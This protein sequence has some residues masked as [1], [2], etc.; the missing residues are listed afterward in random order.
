[1]CFRSELRLCVSIGSWDRAILQL[2]T[3][4]EVPWV[5]VRQASSRSDCRGSRSGPG[6]MPQYK[7]LARCFFKRARRGLF[8]GDRIRYGDQISEDGGNR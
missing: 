8:G 5:L 2:S 4:S 7:Q 3:G 6:A 1:M